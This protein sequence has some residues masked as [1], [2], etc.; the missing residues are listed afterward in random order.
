[1]NQQ[2]RLVTIQDISCTGRCSLTVALPIISSAGIE[3]AVIPTA[4]LSTHTGGFTGYTFRDLTDDFESIEN[5][6]QTLNRP[7][8]AI[9]TGYLAPRQVDLVKDFVKKFKKENTLVL[10]DPAM[11]DGGKMYPGFDLEFAKKMAGLVAMADITVPNLTEACFM[12]GIDYPESYDKEFIHDVLLKL[13]DLGP[14]YAVLSGVSYNKGKV[15]VE[16]YDGK[17]K[18]FTYFETTDVKG[19]FHGSGD[20]FASALISGLL[21][22]L[23]IG[24]SC[25]LAHDMVHSSIL[26][27]LKDQEDDMKFGLHFEKAIPDFIEEIKDRKSGKLVDS[28]FD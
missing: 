14:R 22:G 6:W 11:A 7:F 3:T 12:L 8:D 24:Q 23:S 18:T 20:I 2:K 27:T 1:M 15:G 26:N 21:N 16:C 13:S 28:I 25:Y 19:Y 5:H 17:L 4:V 10:I 9:Y